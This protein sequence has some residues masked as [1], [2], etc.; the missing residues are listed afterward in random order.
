LFKSFQFK[1]RLGVAALR[2][3]THVLEVTSRG[4]YYLNG[5]LGADMPN[6]ISGFLIAH[7]QPNENQHGFDIKTYKD[8]VSVD[9]VGL[10]GTLKK[11]HM[12][13]RDGDTVLSD[14]NAFG[15][16]W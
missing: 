8:L 2:I 6:R 12:L 9:V 13:G 5:L 3:G 15:Q 1:A 14:H 4:I 11:G 7:S 10:M 16:E